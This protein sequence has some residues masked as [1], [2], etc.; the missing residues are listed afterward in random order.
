MNNQ[1]FNTDIYNHSTDIFKQPSY[2]QN[3]FNKIQ[4]NDIYDPYN[5][6][7]R[8]NMFPELFNNY[9]TNPY[10]IRPMNEQAELLTY[11]DAL[12]FA[13]LDLNL[14]LDI[15]PTNQKAIALFNQ[16]NIQKK[17]YIKKYESNYGPLLTNSEYLNNCPWP[18]VKNPWP[19]QNK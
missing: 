12:D 10:E 16:Y 9:K 8:G 7:I 5:G 3:N 13:T 18:W 19:W 6:F 11:I 2:E 15:H 4:Q 1:N 17:E 14:Y